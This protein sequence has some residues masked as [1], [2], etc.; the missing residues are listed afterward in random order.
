M[1]TDQLGKNLDEA[2]GRRDWKGA[3]SLLEEWCQNRPENPEGWYWKALCLFRLGRSEEALAAARRAKTLDPKHERTAQLLARL[4]GDKSS[5]RSRPPAT[6]GSGPPDSEPPP[7]LDVLSREDSNATP[8]VPPTE[9]AGAFQPPATQTGGTTPDQAPTSTQF[10]RWSKGSIIQGRYQVWEVVSGG[11]GEV[12]FVFDREL[13]LDVAIKTPLPAAMATESGRARFFREAEAWILLGLHPNICAAYYV[14]E[15]GGTPRLFIEYI[16]GGSL[17]KWL[18]AHPDVDILEGLDLAMQ[19]ASGML[20]AHTFIWSDEEGREHRGVVHRDLKPANVLIGSDGIARV[21]DF[22]LVGRG[23]DSEEESDPAHVPS[24]HGALRTG[25]VWGTMTLGGKAMGTPLYMPPEQWDGA[26]LAGEPADIYAFGCTL[27]ELFCRRRPF[28]VKLSDTK[29]RP[30]IQLMRWEELHRTAP[31]PNPMDFNP[32]IGP[33]LAGLM[34]QCLAKDPAARPSS[35]ANLRGTLGEIYL[36]IAE[37]PYPR[38]EPK[39]GRLLA[40]AFNNRGV[41][42]ANLGRERGAE[43]AWCEA[44]EADPHHLE[45]S[46]NLALFR[47]LAR[48]ASDSDTLAR[49]DEV[50]KSQRGNWRAQH[51]SGRISLRLGDWKGAEKVLRAAVTDSGRAPNVA[52]DCALSL[53]AHATTQVEDALWI[54]AVQLIA[55]CGGPLRQ[56]PTLLTAYS[57]A[58]T[59]L[60]KI[61]DAIRLYDEACKRDTTL[62]QDLDRG[63]RLLLP[64]QNQAQK[65]E[66][67]VGRVLHSAVSNDGRIAV[68]VLQDG[69]LACW[70]LSN[71]E[72]IRTFS[73]PGGRPRCLAMTPDGKYALAVAQE[74]PVNVCDLQKGLVSHS[75][76]PHP[77]FLNALSVTLDGRRAA[78]VGTTGTVFL[79][80][81]ESR[82]LERSH[83]IHTGYLTTL[84]VAADCR[85]AVIGGNE[86]KCILVDLVDGEILFDLKG[87]DHLVTAVALSRGAR[88]AISGGEDGVIRVWDLVDGSCR[89]QLSGH[90][91]AIRFLSL[92]EDGDLCISASTD[93]SLRHWKMDTGRPV[94]SQQL[95][96]KAF[97]GSATPD[98]KV[99]LLGHSTHLSQFRCDQILGYRAGWAVS[100]PVNVDEAERRASEFGE[101]LE[102][103]RTFATEQDFLAALDMIEQARSVAGYERM[104]EVLN[105]AGEIAATFPREE[106][107]DAWAEQSLEYHTSRVTS[108]AVGPGGKKLLSTG[109]DRKTLLWDLENSRF[110]RTLGGDW[111][112]NSIAVS[113]DGLT[114]LS[115][116]L[117]NNLHLLDLESGDCLRVLSGHEAQVNRIRLSH[118]GQRALS[119]AADGTARYWDLETGVCLLNLG[120]HSGEVFDVVFSPEGRLAAT[121]W[122][123]G[124]ILWDLKNGRELA[125]LTDHTGAVTSLHWSLDGRKLLSAGRDGDVRLWDL[126]R[127]VCVRTLHC[128]LQVNTASL[129]GDG[130]FALA[131]YED[132]TVRLWDIQGGKCLR[133]FSGHRGAVTAVDFTPDGRRAL[134]AGADNDI[135]VWHLDWKV[136]VVPFVEWNDQA[137]P[138]LEVFLARRDDGTGR[139]RWS[140]KEFDALL[141]D[142]GNWGL[143]WIKD[144]GIREELRKMAKSWAGLTRP[145]AKVL[146]RAKRNPPAT[147]GR[148]KE[149][150]IRRRGAIIAAAVILPVLFFVS[151]RISLGRLDF[152]DERMLASR[153]MVFENTPPAFHAQILEDP[154]S[155]GNFRKYLATFTKRPGDIQETEHARH[156][157]EVLGDPAAV[158]PVLDMLRPQERSLGPQETTVLVRDHGSAPDVL[159]LLA[160]MGDAACP[161][162][163]EALL[164][165]DAIVRGT[166]ANALSFHG[167]EESIR[168]LVHKAQDPEPLI[169]IAVSST[170]EQIVS[171]GKLDRQEAFELFEDLARD[172]WPEVRANVAR[173]L[174][175]LSGSSPRKLAEKLSEDREQQVREAAQQAMLLLD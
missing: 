77:G 156:C 116:G 98:W 42:Y 154:C 1:Q 108:I 161:E 126:M 16:D 53:L 155:T 73:P 128:G 124:I 102:A 158:D 160:R 81:L 56:D 109:A 100:S 24:F 113:P 84:A 115:G 51:L 40:G 18:T 91:G 106:L 47:W 48:G 123:N 173:A 17:D 99:V 86:G 67:S 165:D 82:S 72:L 159:A 60:G 6:S 150:R 23:G 117:D 74:N 80:D 39:A 132:G 2:L 49:M 93:G 61:D 54:E 78:G 76:Q 172:H 9:V 151:H 152:N 14:R 34:K 7:T 10:H 30:E 20:H 68:A 75:L 157:L 70:D 38:P 120:G 26:H 69:K 147:P 64:G 166:A 87:H 101:K 131:G 138:Y 96:G 174:P 163:A 29:A 121:C 43:N 143:G 71:A 21:T 19:I 111:N 36:R 133:V 3:H 22:G 44:L 15:I 119:A 28:S 171:S 127:T 167:S 149:V 27:Y 79:W 130:R 140:R 83:H 12:F 142:F 8:K 45:A 137:R 65:L 125:W 144:T 146:E 25:G 94:S 59:R 92:S 118:D 168:L 122:D 134:S 66:G 105:L 32:E 89:H 141:H 148:R 13:A 46:Y 112:E 50:Q 88:H 41:S 136:S 52:R 58:Q 104:N 110:V 107:R 85:S 162:L 153:L 35:F 145:V 5:P 57:L 135:R 103:A 129:S 37:K 33:D 114:A 11:M 4:E 170:L 90:T 139:P 169:R 63:A 95:V 62:P 175:I 164:D 97:C 55:R 31:P